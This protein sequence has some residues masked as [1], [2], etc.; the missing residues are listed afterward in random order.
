VG[1]ITQ[2][3]AEKFFAGE[4]PLGKSFKIGGEDSPSPWV[5]IVGIVG[6]IRYEPWDRDEA[7]YLY[8]PY[9]QTPQRL[10]SLVLRTQGNATTFASAARS[11]IASV[12]ADQP[13]F[14]VESLQTVISNKLLGLSYV[15]VM[16][17]AVGLIA[18]VLA[19]IGVY[20]VMAYSVAERTHEIG[21][22]VALGAQQRE[23]L[24][25]VL[26]RGIVMTAIGLV[27]G[28]PLSL[29]LA[30][31]L[32]DLLYGV[33]SVDVA[34]FGGVTLLMCAITLLA[35]YVPARRAARVDPLVALR[36][37]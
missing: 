19:S 37:E 11:K 18:L 10:A 22:R 32:A 27:I 28:L 15:A 29:G 2:R 3:L 36:Y 25:L 14:E 33:S 24:G 6:N 16:L 8:L 12:D 1:V 7:P 23:V 5:K 35:C 31:L 21:V 20:G 9:R 17:A 13:V 34:T 30:Q 4:R 26:K